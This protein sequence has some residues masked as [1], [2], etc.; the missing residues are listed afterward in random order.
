MQ[1][2]RLCSPAF[3]VVVQSS[4]LRYFDHRPK[5]GILDGGA[6]SVHPSPATNAFGNYDKLMVLIPASSDAVSPSGLTRE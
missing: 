5:V 6:A 2:G 3:V 1:A 4:N